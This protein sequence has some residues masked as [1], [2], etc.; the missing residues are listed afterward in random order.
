[1]KS[2]SQEVK[3]YRG[4]MNQ[5]GGIALSYF[6]SETGVDSIDDLADPKKISSEKIRSKFTEPDATRAIKAARQLLAEY[7]LNTSHF[8]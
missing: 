1:M 2:I 7:D 8:Q 4:D 3:E 6:C 5:M